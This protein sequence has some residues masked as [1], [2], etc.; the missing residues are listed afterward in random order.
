MNRITSDFNKMIDQELIKRF[1]ENKCTAEEAELLVAYFANNPAELD[2]FFPEKTW[3]Q[4]QE[5]P[6]STELSKKML[7]NIL[8]TVQ[9]SIARIWL[10]RTAV[11]ASVVLVSLSAYFFSK[12]L[13]HKAE[14]V[15]EITE[16]HMLKKQTVQYVQIVKSNNSAEDERIR[17]D[18]GSV[19]ILSSGSE[20]RYNQPFTNKQRNIELKGCATFKVAKDKSR[21][22][23]VFAGGV[24]TTALGTSFRINAVEGTSRVNVKLFTGKVVIKPITGAFNNSKQAV[25][26]NPG[27]QLDMNGMKVLVSAIKPRKINIPVSEDLRSEIII[28][29]EEILFSKAPLPSVFAQLSEIYQVSIKCDP[30]LKTTRFTGEVNKTDSIIKILNA[31]SLMNN[32]KVITD[33]KKGYTISK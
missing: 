23:T 17:L 1:T 8:Q 10:V 9:V 19:I 2:R 20:V 27:Q 13:P 12:P 3:V 18:D 16:Q 30:L 4:I 11:A 28:N 25:F 15:A 31:I 22:F 5:Y 21:P 7:K 14:Y 26:L 6:V 33:E 32:L 24:A 29:G